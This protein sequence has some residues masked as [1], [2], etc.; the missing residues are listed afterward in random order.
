MEL[1]RGLDSIPPPPVFLILVA[2]GGVNGWIIGGVALEVRLEEDGHVEFIGALRRKKYWGSR[3]SRVRRR[4]R[5]W[6]RFLSNWLVVALLLGDLSVAGCYEPHPS[7]PSGG[8]SSGEAGRCER[9]KRAAQELLDTHARCSTGDSCVL[10]SHPDLGIPCSANLL[11]Y[12]PFAVNERTD[13]A[14]FVSRARELRAEAEACPRC[15]GPCALP[16]CVSVD[17]L[18]AVC[19]V[20]A[21]RCQSVLR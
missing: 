19:D 21:G 10:V 3:G 12:C 8:C 1:R 13:L 15:G 14:E 7:T 17:Q 5:H 4:T 2:V 11:F 18:S 20:P 16:S 9:A 6:L